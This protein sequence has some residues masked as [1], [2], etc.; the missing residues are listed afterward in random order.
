MSSHMSISNINSVITNY[1]VDNGIP[2]QNNQK[3]VECISTIQNKNSFNEIFNEF[4][5][6]LGPVIEK[7][8]ID[9]ENLNEESKNIRDRAIKSLWIGDLKTQNKIIDLVGKKPTK[10]VTSKKKSVKYDPKKYFN[11]KVSPALKK[12]VKNLKKEQSIIEKHKRKMKIVLKLAMK[13]INSSHYKNK[14]LSYKKK[15]NYT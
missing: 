6:A 10:K 12:Y 9:L 15:P 1:L 7:L 2:D 11:K 3:W 8:S 5:V 13:K 4:V 14:I